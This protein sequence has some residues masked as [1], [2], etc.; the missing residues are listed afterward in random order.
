M[1]KTGSIEAAKDFE[2][3]MLAE[4]TEVE[5]V[6]AL[7]VEGSNYVG[8]PITGRQNSQWFEVIDLND[9][10]DIVCQLKSNEIYTWLYKIG[11]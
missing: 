9:R 11:N 4:W 8:V 7:Q 10:T 3:K 1:H 6:K 2:N 5:G